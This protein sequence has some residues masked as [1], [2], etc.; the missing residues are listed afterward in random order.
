MTGPSEGQKPKDPSTWMGETRDRVASL[1]EYFLAGADRYTPEALR[2][3][4][5]GSGFSPEEID[6]AYSR[7]IDRQRDEE[8]AGPI[9]NRARRTVLVAYGLVYAGFAVAFLTFASR[10]G[11]GV[12]ALVILTIVL[13]V[14]LSISLSWVRRQRP[15]VHEAEGALVTM[16]A[17]PFVLLV[18]VAGLCVAGT[19][20]GS[21]GL[22]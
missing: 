16:L 4:A 9:R 2:Q 6:A 10:R 15:S 3:A 17:V 5:A 8:V 7:A 18:A 11:A 19:T 13:L 12:I 22:F 20:P 14:A 1:S 21:F